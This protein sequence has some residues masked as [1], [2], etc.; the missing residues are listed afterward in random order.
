MTERRPADDYLSLHVKLTCVSICSCME[1]LLCTAAVEQVLHLCEQDVEQ[2]SFL[3]ED[4]LTV[5]GLR[6]EDGETIFLYS[7][8]KIRFARSS[9]YIQAKVLSLVPVDDPVHCIALWR[10]QICIACCQTSSSKMAS[11]QRVS[12]LYTNSRALAMLR[13]KLWA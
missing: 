9:Y 10:Y 13:C 1:C 12:F 2:E 8:K 3:R 6:S 7:N 5:Y 4:I 11:E